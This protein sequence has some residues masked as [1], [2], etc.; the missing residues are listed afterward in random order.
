M[1]HMKFVVRIIGSLVTAWVLLKLCEIL[2]HPKYLG[3]ADCPQWFGFPFVYFYHS[4]GWGAQQ[5]WT[6]QW[7]EAADYA[8]LLL[9]ATFIFLVWRRT[10]EKTSN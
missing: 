3:C 8:V 10:C 4:G 6:A 7:A 9:L 1:T 5:H 2:R